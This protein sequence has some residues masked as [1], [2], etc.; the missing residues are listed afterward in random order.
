MALQGGFSKQEALDQLNIS[1]QSDIAHA[2]GDFPAPPPLDNWELLKQSEKNIPPFNSFW[3]VWKY[4]G[5]DVSGDTVR[6]SVA[7]RGTTLNVFSIEADLLA[8]MFSARGV[9]GNKG[10]YDFVGYNTAGLPPEKSVTLTRSAVHIG[11]ALTAISCV[12]NSDLLETL[13][14]AVGDKRCELFITGHSQ[15]AAVATLFHSLLAYNVP[16]FAPGKATIKSY[17][18]A[19]PKPGNDYYAYDLAMM[20]G[21]KGMFHTVNSTLDFV[22]QVPLTI[23]SLYDVDVKPPTTGNLPGT[24]DPYDVVRKLFSASSQSSDTLSGFGFSVTPGLIEKL[25]KLLLAFYKEK[26]IIDEIKKNIESKELP[27]TLNYTLAGCPVILQGELLD[28]PYQRG[29]PWGYHMPWEYWKELE[30]LDV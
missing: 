9:K 12:E 28:D 3:Q 16:S 5:S 25:L 23:Q 17:V 4:T 7:F 18:F 13:Q 15:G 1:W 19:Q 8:L 22:P 20:C 29:L 21:N 2:T 27:C 14:G 24:A 10:A 26:E 30:K 11:F 6:L